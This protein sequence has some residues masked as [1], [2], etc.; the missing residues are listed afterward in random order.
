LLLVPIFLVSSLLYSFILET[1]LARGVWIAFVSSSTLIAIS[2]PLTLL[3]LHQHIPAV[4]TFLE[5]LP[6]RTISVV[7]KAA[8][9]VCACGTQQECLQKQQARL[10]KMITTI[11]TQQERFT[12]AEEEKI[13]AVAKQAKQ[14][15][16]APPVTPEKGPLQA[17]LLTAPPSPVAQLVPKDPVASPSADGQFR[18]TALAEGA[19]YLN[20][21]VRVTQRSGQ[22]YTGIL[23]A[24]T[25]DAL[26]VQQWRYGGTF[27]VTV[28]HAAVREFQVYVPEER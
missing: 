17:A 6:A 5:A 19:R 18:T 22:K 26:I 27:T 12:L 14:C 16:E 25:S 4:R 2:G 8:S 15:V 11:M 13:A 3:L 28:P 1:T 21:Q 23:T 24:M 7:E 20:Q 9:D 10:T